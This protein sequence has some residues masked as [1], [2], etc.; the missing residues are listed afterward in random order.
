MM[1]RASGERRIPKQGRQAHVGRGYQRFS[2][3]DN[4][5]FRKQLDAPTSARGEPWPGSSRADHLVA[6]RDGSHR[7]STPW[8]CDKGDRQE[9]TDKA[10]WC[11]D[12]LLERGG[13]DVL[14][15]TPSP[16]PYATRQCHDAVR[17]KGRFS[18]RLP[19]RRLQCPY[20]ELRNRTS[21][22]WRRPLSRRNLLVWGLK[23]N[24]PLKHGTV[25]SKPWP[26]AL[27][28]L[29]NLRLRVP[30]GTPVV[31]QAAP[32]YVVR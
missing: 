18:I 32:Q 25:Y 23:R 31:S 28:K 26:T 22:P 6:W 19:R 20:T 1:V 11:G 9:R 15:R 13:E 24:H 12:L 14:A 7:A 4:V 27:D 2:V 16:E 21:S 3:A 30:P 5:Y 10:G 29:K 17:R 8:G